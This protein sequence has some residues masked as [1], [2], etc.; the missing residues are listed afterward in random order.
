[1]E[2]R[3]DITTILSQDIRSRFAVNK[4][5][6]YIQNTGS[7]SVVVDFAKVQF[8]ARCFIDE[9]YNAIMNSSSDIEIKTVNIPEDIQMIF[10]AVKRTQHKVKNINLDATVI[11]C[12][13]FADIQKVFGS[14]SF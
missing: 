10:D 14:L 9:Y 2:T 5:L 1:M 6:R 12:N 3:V 4:L 7:K 8:A 11:K 13:T